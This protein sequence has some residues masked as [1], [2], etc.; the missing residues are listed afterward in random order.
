MAED[1]LTAGPILH[2]FSGLALK[3]TQASVDRHRIWY[4]NSVGFKAWTH[5]LVEF[6]DLTPVQNCL[7]IVVQMKRQ[8]D[9]GEEVAVASTLD[10]VAC[11]RVWTPNVCADSISNYPCIVVNRNID[12]CFATRFNALCKLLKGCNIFVTRDHAISQ[13]RLLCDW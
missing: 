1:R 7:Y 3:L 9:P 12:D 4:L 2:E 5:R 10:A 11:G 6:L 8:F 13:C